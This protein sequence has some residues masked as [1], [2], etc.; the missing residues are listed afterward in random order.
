[1]TTVDLDQLESPVPNSDFQCLPFAVHPP[2]SAEPA[3]LVRRWTGYP[4]D[5]F[6]LLRGLD[7]LARRPL[8]AARISLGYSGGYDPTEPLQIGLDALAGRGIPVFVAA[9]NFGPDSG[10]LQELARNPQVV[11][12]GAVSADGALLRSSSRGQPGQS[13]PMFVADGTDY[14]PDPMTAGTSFAAPRVAHASVYL[15]RC[16]AMS[17]D[18]LTFAR[19]D[20]GTGLSWRSVPFPV[21]G[22]ADTGYDP[23][24]SRW[25]HGPLAASILA[26]GA[27]AATFPREPAETAWYRRVLDVLASTGKSYDINLDLTTRL[28]ALRVIAR[29]VP[30]GLHEVGYGLISTELA[31]QLVSGMLPSHWLRILVPQAVADIGESR[32]SELDRELGNLWDERIVT[33]LRDIL[34]TGIQFAVAKVV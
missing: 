5:R 33:I 30:G 7:W 8:D 16:L 25:E 27:S 23:A 12:V 21:V 9:G 14:S 26:Q 28:R 20:T 22:F 24:K 19:G 6:Y 17:L 32:L 4:I 10:S 1:M 13:G 11:R 3:G 34:L 15:S 18:D 29:P 31:H 2:A